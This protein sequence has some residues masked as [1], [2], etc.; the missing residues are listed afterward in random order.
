MRPLWPVRRARLLVDH[1][2]IMVGFRDLVHKDL[3][4]G[5]F[6]RHNKFNKDHKTE[7]AKQAIR[8]AHQFIY[9]LKH[10]RLPHSCQ[11]R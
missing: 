6:L 10:I 8:P 1:S 4:L 3:L 7:I 11:G 2:G 5:F 9:I